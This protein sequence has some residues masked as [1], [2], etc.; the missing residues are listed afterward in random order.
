MRKLML[1]CA[2]MIGCAED[3]HLSA[4]LIITSNTYCRAVLANTG[5]SVNYHAVTFATG[6][7]IASA[8]V[9][10]S[11]TETNSNNEYDQAQAGWL[12][13]SIIVHRDVTPP[14]NGGW[15]SL[16]LDRRTTV[17]SVT[18]HDE[19]VPNGVMNWTLQSKDCVVKTFSY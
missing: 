19:D 1:L 13:A 8:G 17:T 4:D 16:S 15:W 5:L 7:I 18:Y 3:S 12:T 9:S 6:N 11:V 2:V 14:D 10:D